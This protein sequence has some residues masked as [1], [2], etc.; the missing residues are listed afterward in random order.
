MRREC[1]FY[2][3]IQYL[4]STYQIAMLVITV[5]G[6]KLSGTQGPS[7]CALSLRSSATRSG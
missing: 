6:D 7:T 3:Y 1:R 4:A 5:E 2:V